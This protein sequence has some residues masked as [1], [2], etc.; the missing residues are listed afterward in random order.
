MTGKDMADNVQEKAVNADDAMAYPTAI[1][2]A[3]TQ[4]TGVSI[5]VNHPALAYC[6]WWCA[7]NARL[8]GCHKTMYHLPAAAVGQWKKPGRVHQGCGG[9]GMQRRSRH[10]RCL[11]KGMQSRRCR[12]C[13]Q[14]QVEHQQL[15]PSI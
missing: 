5:Q 1:L 2:I 14:S 4:E 11:N 12:A 10:G 6:I 13:V 15:A 3:D 9:Q 8:L 7:G